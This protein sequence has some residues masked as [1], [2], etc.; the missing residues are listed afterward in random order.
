MTTTTLADLPRVSDQKSGWPWSDTMRAATSDQIWP[1]IS[2][3][4]ISQNNASS[5]EATIRSVLLQGYPNLEYL[6]IDIGSTDGSLDIIRKYEQ[7]LT[8][9]ES[10]Q[11]IATGLSE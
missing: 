3:V 4:T 9:I 6:V 7:W 2:V 8:H 10:S 1:K 11:N 5:L